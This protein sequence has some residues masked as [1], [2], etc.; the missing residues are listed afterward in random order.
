[1]K[2]RVEHIDADAKYMKIRGTDGTRMLKINGAYVSVYDSMDNEACKASYSDIQVGDYV[3][4]LAS[5]SAIR[6]VTIY[7]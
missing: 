3:V 6:S 2:G 1:M 5:T 7:R 4:V